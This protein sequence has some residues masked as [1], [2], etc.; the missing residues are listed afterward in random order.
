MSLPVVL[1][2]LSRVI[3]L[4][5]QPPMTTHSKSCGGKTGISGTS[6]LQTRPCVIFYCGIVY[7]QIFV[8]QQGDMAKYLFSGWWSI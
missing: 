7:K 2:V 4:S 8:K 3:L 5:D 6:S 1:R